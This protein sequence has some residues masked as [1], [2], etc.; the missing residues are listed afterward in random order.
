MAALREENLRS[1]WRVRSTLSKMLTKRGYLM[2][3]GYGTSSF[4]DFKTQCERD[5]P[6]REGRQ[7]F[8]ANLEANEEV[9]IL[10]Q[11]VDTEKKVGITEIRECIENM[12]QAQVTHTIVVSQLPWSAFATQT[13]NG[14]P[15]FKFESFLVKQLLVDITEH[16][17]VPEHI[18]LTPEEKGELLRR[19]H[20]KDTQLPR[21]KSDDPIAKYFGLA[22]G[23]VVKIVRASETAGRYV[24]YRIVV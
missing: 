2:P 23:Q 19:Y 12:N 5:D 16:E 1:M 22:R 4:E 6:L 17:L 11:F 13:A 20:L 24:T 10:V 8:I 15:Q 3:E 14:L 9:K 21:M 18:V 7:A